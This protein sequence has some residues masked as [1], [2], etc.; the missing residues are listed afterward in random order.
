MSRTTDRYLFF[1]LFLIHW[2][3]PSL[4]NYPPISHKNNLLDPHQ[5]GFK[6]AHST[7]TACLWGVWSPDLK[8]FG[9]DLVRVTLAAVILFFPLSD[10]Y[11]T[12][13]PHGWKYN[14]LIFTSICTRVQITYTDNYT[15]GAN[16]LT[17]TL[18][19]YYK[20]S[21]KCIALHTKQY[22]FWKMKII[23]W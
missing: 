5:S 1:H 16:S 17:I 13:N 4:T 8:T 18:L 3:V 10:Q 15:R 11:T 22:K 19:F 7:E 2:K 6:T 23:I 12:V 21:H 14:T 9:E 20:V